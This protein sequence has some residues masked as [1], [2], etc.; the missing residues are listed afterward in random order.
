MKLNYFL[1]CILLL[2]TLS[3]CT[4]FGKNIY[5]D[6]RVYN[7][8]TGEGIEGVS[9][10]LYRNKIDTKDPIGTD[11]KTLETV[12][13]D[14]NGYYKIEYLASPFNQ[15]FVLINYAGYHPL[16]WKENGSLGSN[17][18]KKGKRNHLDYEMVPY[19]NYKLIVNNINCQGLG[20]TIILKRTN[21]TESFLV[22]DWILTGCDGYSTTMNKVPMGT[23]YTHYI[24][25]RN[26]VSNE[27]DV[28][29]EVLP[30]QDN[31]QTINY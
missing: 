31:I 6:G 4:K 29:F 10:T 17:G 13:T 5:V 24:V 2:I 11:G 28:N 22:K 14:E 18:I 26:G 16:G 23:I 8:I 20:D 1:V 25:I 9:V 21:Q 30:N 15:A 7:P 19:G 3:T 27:Y 12:T